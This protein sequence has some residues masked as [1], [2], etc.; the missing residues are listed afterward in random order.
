MCTFCPDSTGVFRHF[1]FQ[2]YTVNFT[3]EIY[4][5]PLQATFSPCREFLT[6]LT[7]LYLTRTKLI[8][9]DYYRPCTKY[10]G[11]LCFQFVCLSTKEVGSSPPPSRQ[12]SKSRRRIFLFCNEVVTFL[13]T[14]TS[15]SLYLSLWHLIFFVAI[16]TLI[17]RL[18]VH[19]Q[20]SSIFG[21]MCL[22]FINIKHKCNAF[23]WCLIFSAPQLTDI[24]FCSLQ[25]KFYTTAFPK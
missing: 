12:E 3:S 24:Y 25:M 5:Y 16:N 22:S 8:F 14:C 20:D 23:S 13:A 19:W 21:W 7:N 1:I 15:C 11:R 2:K 10:D 6:F 18:F 17:W 4:C 9:A